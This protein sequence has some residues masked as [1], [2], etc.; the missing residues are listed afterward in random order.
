[1]AERVIPGA[2]PISESPRIFTID[3]FAGEA[4]P[5]LAQ[6]LIPREE[7][8]AVGEFL[9][10]RHKII[11]FTSGTYDMIHI[12]HGR[13][14]ELA[15]YLGDVFVLGLNSDAS[16]RAYKGPDR[17]ILEEMK[18]AEMLAY[19]SCVDYIVIYDQPTGAETIRLL[20]PHRYLCVEGSW[21]K[22][23]RLEDKEEVVA[24]AEHG[25]E[26]YCSPRQEPHLSTSDII[27]RL[28]LDGKHEAALEM[29]R[30]F[31]GYIDKLPAFRA[32]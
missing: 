13:Y 26:T 32:L 19:L 15:R 3:G 4:H 14:L 2:V 9:R 25:G 20:K 24:M 11:S 1:M 27:E 23:T 12:G 6:K 31:T 8:P 21:P 5:L 17:P 29:Q 30:A 10:R 28:K 18:R 16:V 22:G 7:L